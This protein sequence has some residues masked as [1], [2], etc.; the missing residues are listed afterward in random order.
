MFPTENT[1]GP[2]KGPHFLPMN[3]LAFL[4]ILVLGI[5]LGLF[6]GYVCEYLERR[7]TTASTTPGKL[8]A[9]WYG[10]G[11]RGSPMANGQPFDPDKMTCATYLYPLGSVIEVTPVRP[12]PGLRRS[13]IVTVT[14]RGPHVEGRHVDL[15]RAAFAA[16]CTLERGLIGVRLRLI[17]DKRG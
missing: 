17:S 14:D 12:T 4:S 13:V 9:S 3:T 2:R 10:E 15:S 8:I 7:E 1:T 16:I 6:V 5:G 11:Y